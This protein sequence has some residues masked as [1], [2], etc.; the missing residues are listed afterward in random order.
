MPTAL[1]LSPHLDDAAF[2]CGGLLAS[3]A[4]EGWRVVMA[5]LFTGS[6]VDPKGFALACQLDKGLPAEI[7]YMALR[8]AEDV[9]AVEELG[10]AP[11]LHLP[12]REAPHRGYGSAPELFS[13][14]RAD[15][16]IAADLAPALAEL[17]A[18]ERPDLILAPQAVGGHV[19]HVQAVRALTSLAVPIPILWWRDFPYTVREATPREPLADLFATLPVRRI[20]LDPGAR[21]RKR[22]ACAAYTSQI[23]FQFGGVAGLDA[24]L[25]REEGIEGFRL[26]GRLGTPIPGL[27]AG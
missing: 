8:R 6:V 17:V 11:P 7:D 27:D 3:L 9:R 2:S 13:A 19:D 26:A 18:A 1:A 5:T 12:F 10:I 24:R 15:D 22:A 14:P 23:G 16:G 21:A 20:A 4:G 25:A